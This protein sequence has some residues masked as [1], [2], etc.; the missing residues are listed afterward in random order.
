MRKAFAYIVFL[1]V[2]VSLSAQTDSQLSG[3][4]LP[5][6]MI[7]MEGAF[8]EPLQV[9]DSVLIADQVFYGFE[10]NGVEEGTQFAFPSVKDT[11][12]TGIEIV[13]PWRMDTLKTIKGKKS[14]ASHHS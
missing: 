10:L 14:S 11:L 8:L 4:S 6:K 1:M 9:R 5:G 3:Q 7:R 2:S 12:M 13:Q